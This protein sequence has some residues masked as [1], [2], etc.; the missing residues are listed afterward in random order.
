MI[1]YSASSSF[2]LSEKLNQ[3]VAAARGEYICL[4]NDDVEAITPR[5]GEELIGYLAANP[6]VGAIGPMCLREDKTIQQNGVVLLANG[7]AHAGEGQPPT[8][9]GH[10]AML[11]CRREAFCIGGAV[12]LIK[13]DLYEALGGF[14]EDLPLNYNDVD[15]CL[16]LRERGYSCVVDPQIEVFH[17]ESATKTGT[18]AVEQE[19][20]FLKHPDVTDPYFSRWFDQRSPQYQLK[21]TD[22]NERWDFGRWLDRHIAHRARRFV[23]EGRLKLSV[24][25]SVY[26]QPK[27][28][29]DEMYTS[30][31]MQTYRNK[32]IIIL[33]NGSSNDETVEWISQAETR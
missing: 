13:K 6:R 9:G 20:L 22:E 16:R 21:L 30:L 12:L 27:K 17:F 15:F 18:S 2:N 19:R 11:R 10:Q 23:P 5:G 32:E 29:L 26:N 28:L 31:L 25:V 33:D 24:C 3:G 1:L 14:D 8:F 7:P 4:L